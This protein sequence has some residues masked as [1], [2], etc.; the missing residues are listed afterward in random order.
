MDVPE[1]F[2]NREDLWQFPREPAAPDGMN[3]GGETRMAPYYI[4]MRLPGEPNTEFF[5]MLPMTPS[6]RLCGR[7]ETD[8]LRQDPG[9]PRADLRLA[10]EHVEIT[11][12]ADIGLL[13][14]VLSLAIISH[15]AA[16]DP[17]EP[18]VV[19]LDNQTDGRTVLQARAFDELGFVLRDLSKSMFGHGDSGWVSICVFDLDADAEGWFPA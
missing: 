6:Q 1:V 16:C 18:A 8:E 13:K 15:D 3:A 12:S 2:Y 9:K 11:E 7:R 4:M 14:H 17:V 19:L 5:L 10:P